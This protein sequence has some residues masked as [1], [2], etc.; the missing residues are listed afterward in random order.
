MKQEAP[1]SNSESG[2]PGS[3]HF[4]LASS[5][6]AGQRRSGEQPLWWEWASNNGFVSGKFRTL[7]GGTPHPSPSEKPA[8]PHPNRRRAG[9]RS[10]LDL[11]MTVTV[12]A[13]L[14]FSRSFIHVIFLFTACLWCSKALCG[15]PAACAWLLAQRPSLFCGAAR[16]VLLPFLCLPPL[17][18][19]RGQQLTGRLPMGH[20]AEIATDPRLRRQ[21]HPALTLAASG[22]LAHAIPPS[23]TFLSP[24]QLFSRSWL[25]D[26]S[27][28]ACCL[29]CCRQLSQVRAP[30]RATEGDA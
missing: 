3:D 4:T 30:T 20:G 26:S 28:R 29:T 2:A 15:A 21:P 22:V 25:S 7:Y 9:Q 14:P 8:A 24:R 17:P 10:S 1:P 19:L 13:I 23:S 11:G 5:P 12:G 27:A 16:R 6:N 18:R